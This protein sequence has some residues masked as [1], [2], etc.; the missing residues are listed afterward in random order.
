MIALIWYR[1]AELL[2]RFLPLSASY[3]LG[4]RMADFVY[5]FRGAKRRAI[6][7]N[8]RQVLKGTSRYADLEQDVRR[9]LRNFSALIVDFLRVSR[10]TPE[11]IG[12]LC[13]IDGLEI[14]EAEHR[15]VGKVV[16][17]TAHLGN[18]ELG[19]VAFA[20]RGLPLTVIALPHSTRPVTDFFSNHRRR[21]GIRVISTDERADRMLKTLLESEYIALVGDRD[22]TGTGKEVS[23]FG[24]PTRLPTGPAKLARRTGASLIPAFAVREPGG[25]YSLR[26]D[27][28]IPLQRTS[29]PR[30]DLR[31]NLERIGTVLE[32]WIRRYPDQWF[33][34]DP[35]WKS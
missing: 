19:G 21:M 23:F 35:L 3:W 20:R 29:S 7:A 30:E 12:A 34:F 33:V 13:E 5:L 31:V 11:E 4:E 6:R 25:T 16:L 22:L 18:W 10:L 17:L 24:E 32:S 9:V 28:P 14:V 15:R 8:L 1:I 26:F 27:R 2:V